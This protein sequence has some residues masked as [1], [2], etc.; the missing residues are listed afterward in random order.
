M[1]SPENFLLATIRLAPSIHLLNRDKQTIQLGLALETSMQLPESFRKVL[2]KCDG[3]TSVQEIAEHSC[4]LGF[5]FDSTVKTL[6]LLT[7]R[8]LLIEQTPAL[9]KLTSNQASHLLDAQRA[10]NSNPQAIANRTKARVT[11]YGAGRVGTTIAL[12]LGNSGFAN[13]NIIDQKFVSASDISPW[14]ASRIDI[15][16]RRDFIA[17]TLL[18]RIHRQQLKAI[19]LKETRSKPNLI[20]FAPDPIADIPWLNPNLA[21]LALESD[22]PFLV[23]AT[24]PAS[25]LISSVIIPG[26]AGCVRCYHQH[27]NDRDSA[28][29]QLIAQLVGREMPDQ[30]PTDLVLS[31][32]LFA[33]QQI[34]SWID[35]GSNQSNT[36]WKIERDSQITQFSNFP[37]SQCGCFWQLTKRDIA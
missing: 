10:T 32:S 26:V 28:W 2:E 11:I 15:G 9:N 36:W 21:D 7:D 27:Q 6:H 14:G 5:D 1:I 12:L 22:S 25:S 24:S 35:S 31:S 29:P 4:D 33:Y 20:V 23:V 13:L 37:H 19:R 30:T 8:G 3:Y 17:Q 18:E 34:A 16:Q